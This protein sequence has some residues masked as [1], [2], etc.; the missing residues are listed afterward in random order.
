MKNYCLLIAVILF[1]SAC[2]TKKQDTTDASEGASNEER[3]SPV[4]LQLKWET[5]SALTTCE[6]VIYDEGEDILYVANI[7]GQPDEK[8]GNG[9]ISKVSLEGEVTEQKWITG[10]DAPKGMGLRN[11]TLYVTDI[12]RVHEIDTETGKITKTHQV[13]GAIFLNDIA[14]DNAK[15]YVSDSGGGTIYLLEDGKVSAWME[16]LK[17]PNGLFTDNGEILVA[18]WDAKTLNSVDASS[19]EITQRTEDIENPDGIEAIG[20]N[21]YLVSSWNGMVHH[22]DGDW[23]KTLVLDTR[24]ESLNAAD[25]EY[26]SSKNLLLVPTFFKNK[27]MAYEVVK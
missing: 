5:D 14:V 2:E 27:V 11:G 9:F 25:I 17:G 21:E 1:A 7:A 3:Q 23:K 13:E 6:S 4:T 8:D 26:V 19:K 24:G 18:L 10:M 20:N 15:V 22:I 12:D 16:N